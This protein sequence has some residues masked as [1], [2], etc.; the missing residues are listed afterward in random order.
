MACCECI[1]NPFENMLIHLWLT[2][3]IQLPKI[4]LF[5]LQLNQSY[6]YWAISHFAVPFYDYVIFGDNGRP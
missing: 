6:F 5:Q 4:K 2:Y 1:V 3:A